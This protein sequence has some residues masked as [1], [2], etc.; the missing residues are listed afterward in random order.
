MK[1]AIIDYGAGNLRSIES[2]LKKLGQEFEIIKKPEDLGDFAKVI[3]PGVGAAKSAMNNLKKQ[4]FSKILA[5]LKI[6]F[7]GICLGLQLL[8]DFSREDNVKCLSIIPGRVKKFPKFVKVPQIGWNKVNFV[9]ESPLS[10][11]IP[12][13]SY[14]YFVNSFY[15]ETDRDFLT[16]ESD[17][18]ITFPSII[19]K[20]N[21]YATQFHPEKSGEI[22]AKLLFNFCKK[23]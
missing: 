9:K 6:P 22:G 2:A 5:Q 3:L 12:N 19:Q 8:S 13:E 7:L 21:F 20:D 10:D 1:I 14:F 17:Y 11:D 15:F 23:C 16:A 4:G 18:G